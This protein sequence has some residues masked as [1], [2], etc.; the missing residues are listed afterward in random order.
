MVVV[1][2]AG[3]FEGLTLSHQRSNQY[4]N[5][6]PLLS[7]RQSTVGVHLVVF[8]VVQRGLGSACSD[9]DHA[10]AHGAMAKGRLVVVLYSMWQLD[11]PNYRVS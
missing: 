8:L 9:V 5:N 1:D 7:S 6:L 4:Y 3:L 10:A 11:P 2:T